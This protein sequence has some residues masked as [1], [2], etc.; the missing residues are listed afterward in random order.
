[1]SKASV[2]YGHIL[3]SVVMIRSEAN[4]PASVTSF[5]QSLCGAYH[6]RD[7]CTVKET[8]DCIQFAASVW[9]CDKP[10][11]LGGSHDHATMNL[12]GLKKAPA[13]IYHLAH[14][15]ADCRSAARSGCA[16]G[17]DLLH[18]SEARAATL[19]AK[20]PFHF[21]KRKPISRRS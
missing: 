20:E 16:I 4:I 19:K 10:S 6:P 12:R 11:V 17:T 9:S 18:A 15:T 14:P 21:A 13:S 1:M 2:Q 5:I 3:L 7:R 8:R